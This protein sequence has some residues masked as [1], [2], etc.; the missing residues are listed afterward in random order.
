MPR[1]HGCFLFI[2]FIICIILDLFFQWVNRSHCSVQIRQQIRD[3]ARQNSKRKRKSIVHMFMVYFQWWAF[4]ALKC[5][6]LILDLLWTPCFTFLLVGLESY[7]VHSQP[8]PDSVFPEHNIGVGPLYLPVVVGP[9]LLHSPLLPWS[10]IHSYVLPVHHQDGEASNRLWPVHGL[11]FQMVNMLIRK[12]YF[13][14]TR[15]FSRSVIVYVLCFSHLSYDISVLCRH[16]D[17]CWPPLALW[18]SFISY[19]R[20]DM[21]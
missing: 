14:S 6:A 2:S 21:R 4:T 3:V 19:W 5:W 8:W 10:W 20:G 18:S 1:L 11:L 13:C 15:N 16:W 17:S 7:M 12:K 9:F